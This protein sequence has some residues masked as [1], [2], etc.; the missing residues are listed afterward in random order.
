MVKG[1]RAQRSAD[2]DAAHLTTKLRPSAVEHLGRS[3][4]DELWLSADGSAVRTPYAQAMPH[5]LPVQALAGRLVPGS[6]TL[7]VRGLTP[8][9]RGMLYQR[10]WRR[11]EPD[12][13][14]EPHAVQQALPTVSP[15]LA[16]LTARMSVPWI[17]HR[18][19]DAVAVWRVKHTERLIAYQTRAGAGREGAIATARRHLRLGACGNHAGGATGAATATQRA[20]RASRTVGLS[21]VP[22]ACATM[23]MCGDRAPARKSRAP[24][25]WWK[26]VCWT[27]NWTP[28]SC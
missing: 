28:G 21:P 27:P 14:S 24:W 16:P 1:E 18:E 25:G 15:A 13:V 5:L 26:C 10:R 8:T 22:C 3:T 19:F 20:A 11:Q 4:A 12:C 23:P 17:L 9:P 7:T 6:R 2:L